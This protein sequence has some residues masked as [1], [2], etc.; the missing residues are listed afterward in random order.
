MTSVVDLWGVAQLMALGTPTAAVLVPTVTL[1]MWYRQLRLA[2]AVLT[3]DYRMPLY[4]PWVRAI[5]RRT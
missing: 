2:W 3:G 1:M 4:R 5:A